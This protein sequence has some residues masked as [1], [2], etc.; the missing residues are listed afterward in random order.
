[1]GLTTRDEEAAAAAASPEVPAPPEEGGYHAVGE[2]WLVNTGWLFTGLAL[3][4]SQLPFKLMLKSG[5]GFS[6]DQLAGFMAIANIPIYIKPLV[7]ILSDA[8]PF[9]GTR[10]RDYLLWGLLGA[11]LGWWLLGIVPRGYHSLLYAYLALNVFLTLNSTVLGGLMVEV[12]KRDKMTGKLSAQRLGITRL[13]ELVSGPAGGFLARQ[14]FLLTA[15]LCGV[16]NLA[17]VPFIYLFLKE[18]RVAQTNAGALREVVRQFRELL[19]S[20]TLWAA[21]GLVI[22]VIAAPGFETPLLFHQTDTLKFSPE[23]IGSLGIVKAGG[24]ILGAVIYGILCRRFNLRQLLAMSIVNH[25]VMTLFYLLYRS[26]ISAIVISGVEA[27]TLVLALLPLY[28]LAARATPR[29]SEALG[30]SLMMSV[31]NFTSSMSDLAGSW[32]YRI[33]GFNLAN[34]VFINAGTTLLVLLA[35]PFLPAL[36]M[37]RRDGDAE[38]GGALAH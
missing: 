22:L 31:W 7:G 3:S 20:R 36:L 18:P 38:R 2:G 28:D 32:V 17:L 16:L 8:V 37:D 25:A 23:F 33:S 12:G 14:A 6:P 26:H 21:A 30:Y 27:T 5:M 15:G 19:R 10:R 9:C 1:M 13:V 24:G 11:S 35:V 34:L 29:G 4:L